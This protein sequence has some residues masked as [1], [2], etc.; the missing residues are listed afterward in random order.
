M[1]QLDGASGAKR[2]GSKVFVR[3]IS[4]A[5]LRGRLVLQTFLLLCMAVGVFGQNT[6]DGCGVHGIRQRLGDHANIFVHGIKS[7]PRNVIRPENLKWELPVVAGTV[8]LIEK[9]DVRAADNI[10][11]PTLVKNADRATNVGLAIELGSGALAYGAGCLQQNQRLR[12]TGF[13]AVTAMGEAGLIDLGMK[14][15]FDRHLPR[16]PGVH[17]SGDFWSGGRAFPSGHS[18]TSF[19]F[20]SAVAHRYPEKTWLKWGVYGLA[21]GVSVLR[22]PAKKHFPS[23]IVIGGALGYVIGAYA[24]EHGPH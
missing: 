18:A 11:S 10:T 1:L 6:Y 13:T 17:S 20:A 8:L 19:A 16:G 22:Y 3:C 5:M 21:T 12:E 23:D 4:G 14:L 15:A 24:A 7:V 2:K 9:A